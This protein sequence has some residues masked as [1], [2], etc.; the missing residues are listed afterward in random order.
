MLNVFGG[1][2]TTYR[3]L[4]EHALDKIVPIVGG[5]AA[6]WTAGVPLP[7]GDF[8]VG[9]VGRLIAALKVAYPFLTD[10]WATRLVK[11]YGT[12]AATLLQG[13][14]GPADLGRDFGATLTEREV[15]W[16]IT[17]EFARTA[18]D[19]VWRRN[20]L[21]LRLKADEVAALDDWM[22]TAEAEA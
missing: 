14:T 9:D 8:P 7:G 6:G 3:R 18:E 2:I 5:K 20:K 22:R 21:G 15:R 10:R 19:V 17:H 12:E 4:A 1:K 16:L 13:A 11:A